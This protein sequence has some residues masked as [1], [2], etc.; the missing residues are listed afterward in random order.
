MMIQVTVGKHTHTNTHNL[1]I[2]TFIAQ[3]ASADYFRGRS[4]HTDVFERLSQLAEL[5]EALLH[6]TGGPL[7][8]SAV[9]V[10]VSSYC[11]FH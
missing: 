10:G 5:T 2:S 1:V 4:T 6:Y 3:E 9:L 11:C 8:H 7:I